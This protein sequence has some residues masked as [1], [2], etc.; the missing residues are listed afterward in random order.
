[1]NGAIDREDTSHSLTHSLA[2]LL[3]AALPTI[4]TAGSGIGT[5]SPDND[6]D[7]ESSDATKTGI[8]I[9]NKTTGDPLINFQLND[10][11]KFTVGVDNSDSDKL[12]I[13]TD[14]T[15]ATSDI[16]VDASGNVGIGTIAVSPNI[17]YILN[18]QTI[19]HNHNQLLSLTLQQAFDGSQIMS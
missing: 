5:S 13:S 12:K 4:A 1:M 18:F 17:E 9:N 15:F 8:D 11:S 19:L 7:I 6:L 2:C 10:A 14:S 3:I 16:T